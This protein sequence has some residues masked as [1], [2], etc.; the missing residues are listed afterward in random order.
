MFKTFAAATLAAVS[1]GAAWTEATIKEM[2]CADLGAGLSKSENGCIFMDCL[3]EI[4]TKADYTA[5]KSAKGAECANTGKPAICLK[6]IEVLKDTACKTGLEKCAR[7]PEILAHDD[8]NVKAFEDKCKAPECT[9][10]RIG[11][12]DSRA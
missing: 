11:Y 9:Y 1:Y 7:V 8:A 2:S 3:G 12:S 5:E 6:A 4:A 10:F